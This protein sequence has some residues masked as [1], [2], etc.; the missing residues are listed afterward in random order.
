[1]KLKASLAK[2]GDFGYISTIETNSGDY[3]DVFQ[4][5]GGTQKK[6]CL[7]TAKE[8]RKAAARFELLAQE[9]MPCS[10]KVQARINRIKF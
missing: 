4:R 9:G 8:L 7:D 10:S 1:M 5:T 3:I 6:I 2:F